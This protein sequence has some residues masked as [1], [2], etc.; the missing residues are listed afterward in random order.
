MNNSKEVKHIINISD[1]HLNDT[2]TFS[3][4]SS[5]SKAAS[6]STNT[7][8][9]F[10]WG[11]NKYGELGLGT[12]TN[13]FFPKKIKNVKSFIINTIKSGGR[14]T[15]IL[16]S[17][18]KIYIAGS[19]I[20]S[21]LINN[22]KIQNNEQYQKTFK[23]IKYFI[24]NEEIIK[25]ISI[26]EFHSLALNQN[27]EIF[28][29]GGNLFKKLG[30]SNLNTGIPCRIFIEKKIISV[31]CGDYHSCALSED[32]FLYSWGGGGDSYNKGQCGHGNKKDINEPTIIQYFKKNKKFII[33][34]VC[35]GYHTIAMTDKNELYGF[36]K[37]IYG[38]CGYGDTEDIFIPKKIIFDEKQNLKYENND[39]IKIIDIKCGGEHSLFL[40][41]NNNVYSCGHG[42]FG[43]LGLGNN[44]NIKIPTIIKSLTN[45]KI[46][47]IA[48]GWSHSIVLTNEGNVYTCGC[49]KYGE[50]GL[51]EVNNKYNF[52]WVKKLSKYNIKQI[53][54]GG[55]HSFCVN[56][57][58]HPV[59]E[60]IE[61]E[62]LN[63]P[64]FKMPIRKFSE[65]NIKN[66]NDSN[67]SS[68]SNIR[69]FSRERFSTSNAISVDGKNK[70]RDYSDYSYENNIN[71]NNNLKKIFDDFNKFKDCDDIDELIDRFNGVDSDRKEKEKEK[72]NKNDKI[73]NNISTINNDENDKEKSLMSII[74]NNKDIFEDN[75]EKSIDNMNEEIN[76]VKFEKSKEN[77]IQF[78]SEK[79][80]GNAENKTKNNIIEISKE[81]D[82]EIN[83][84][85]KKINKDEIGIN[86][87][88]IEGIE[89]TKETKSINKE[90]KDVI[91]K[92]NKEKSD[93][94]S[95]EKINKDSKEKVSKKNISNKEIHVIKEIREIHVIK[96]TEKIKENKE[97]NQIHVIKDVKE[98]RNNSKNKQNNSRNNYTIKEIT[99]IKNNNTK[100]DQINYDNIS[101]KQI[102]YNYN[103]NFIFISNPLIDNINKE[104]YIIY[105]DLNL[106]HRFIK[107]EIPKLIH[108]NFNILE[109][110]I[111][112]FISIDNG[113]LSYH[114]QNDEEILTNPCSNHIISNLFE[115]MKNSNK[116]TFNMNTNSFTLGV[117]YDY[118]KNERAKK[119]KE[120]CGN[121]IYAVNREKKGPLY[122]NKILKINQKL[123]SD[124]EIVLSKWVV[125]FYGMFSELFNREQWE[126]Y[127]SEGSM[128]I[129]KPKFL[130][131]R[132]KCFNL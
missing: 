51:G 28:G 115:Q 77:E 24:E 36:G 50:L 26:A 34:V 27:G 91:N 2:S 88:N 46:I 76:K 66:D 52:I 48:A 54:A 131:L 33:K 105:C 94:N 16:S 59:K 45:K 5:S 38:Q 67:T 70:R 47:S 7:S 96:E 112:K 132:P 22:T 111:K 37:G 1:P 126:K 32:G 40:S 74:E 103:N 21:L 116:I 78:N 102:K 110:Q 117:V 113:N 121:L 64:N 44:K 3:V 8:Y 9:I 61:P 90:I 97:I 106:S 125:D 41:S 20:F 25:E 128:I 55:H 72:N 60:E 107:F 57:I 56:D 101:Q 87:S 29:W 92:Q 123:T 108:I 95:M 62:P 83:R 109:S 129:N 80:E 86:T 99:N 75:K 127:Y 19:N 49:G 17:K 18:G 53:Y 14:N 124:N 69:K 73:I 68:M 79:K 10:A 15:L 35:G 11:K 82:I 13:T 114:L 4:N 23:Q 100:K 104:L 85:N 93:K 6:L 84:E 98:N 120:K 42:Y 63:K 12:A 89:Q 81:N 119:V 39:F 30:Q 118:N 65:S 58:E 122:G 130:E 43:Q 31:S 71:E